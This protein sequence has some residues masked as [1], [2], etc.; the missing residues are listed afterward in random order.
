MNE[1]KSWKLFGK[2]NII[3][4]LIIL[5]VIAAL[6]LLGSRLLRSGKAQT[7][8]TSNQK[9]IVTF[10]GFDDVSDFVIDA[11]QEGDGVVLYPNNTAIGKL[12]SFE[13][14]PAYE[15]VT[16][17]ETGVT[18]KQPLD[19]LCFLTITVECNGAFTRSGM[20]IEDTTFVV[21]GNYYLTVGPTRAEYRLMT[22]EPAG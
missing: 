18:S 1:K 4:L 12:L 8:G 19:G 3:D 15:S 17:P 21:G 6:I 20:T 9:T 7:I 22:M 16:D 5:I 10:Y 14:E 2:L 11:M 13:S